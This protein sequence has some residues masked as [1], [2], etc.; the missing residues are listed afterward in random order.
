MDNGIGVNL[1][2]PNLVIQQV[3]ARVGFDGLI[4]G[5]QQ[6]RRRVVF[7]K[8][9]DGLVGQSQLGNRHGFAGDLEL[10]IGGQ[11][12][13]GPQVVAGQIGKHETKG[14]QNHNQNDYNKQDIKEIQLVSF[15]VYHDLYLLL[16]E[17]PGQTDQV[18]DRGM[19]L[20]HRQVLQYYTES[21]FYDDD[22]LFQRL[23]IKN[24]GF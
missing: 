21:P 18:Y 11:D 14:C 15:L 5:P 16:D 19:L 24:L 9:H 6:W 8:I 1:I 12:S 13:V 3:N 23:N 20:Q 2:L 7:T 17:V 22:G 10:R 4:P